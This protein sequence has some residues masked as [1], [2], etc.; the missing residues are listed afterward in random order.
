[1]DLS[2]LTVKLANVQEA[3]LINAFYM[4]NSD[5]DYGQDEHWTAWK[6]N[7]LYTIRL[8]GF[9]NGIFGSIIGY[10]IKNG[11]CIVCK[12]LCKQEVTDAIEKII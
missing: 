12:T 2:K 9:I 10:W 5:H 4:H 3:G 8:D 11:N 7:K 6:E 1:M